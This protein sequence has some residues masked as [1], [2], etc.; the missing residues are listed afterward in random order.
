ME[1]LD[2]FVGNLRYFFY[3]RSLFESE[4]SCVAWLF[5]LISTEA[6]MKQLIKFTSVRDSFRECRKRLLRY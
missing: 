4:I 2:F 3:F 6:V 1:H 5:L